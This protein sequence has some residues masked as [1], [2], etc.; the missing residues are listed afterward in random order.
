AI[1]SSYE[2]RK[3]ESLPILDGH[4][5]DTMYHP[6]SDLDVFRSAYRNSGW[7][8]ETGNII[9]T[10]QISAS[11]QN[12]MKTMQHY[13]LIFLPMIFSVF[14]MAQ[15]PTEIVRFTSQAEINAFATNYPNCTTINYHVNIGPSTDIIDLRPLENITSIA[16]DIKIIEN[17]ALTSLD[18]LQALS[19]IGASF[20]IK[21]NPKLNSLEALEGIS[22]ITGFFIVNNCDALI[23][24][25]G[26]ENI[27][28]IGGSLGIVDNAM[29]TSLSELENLT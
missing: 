19:G 26:I 16:G 4:Y 1:D 11:K 15:C 27:T 28:Y 24:L 8:S 10:I 23:S 20:S 21:D 7:K 17:E 6:L 14:T 13:F 29:L 2:I 5:S 18:G 25:S 12:I 3:P 9:H 22:N